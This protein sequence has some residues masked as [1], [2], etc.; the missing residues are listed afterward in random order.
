MQ[1]GCQ[2]SNISYLADNRSC[3]GTIEF[4]RPLVRHS[5][6]VSST[7]RMRYVRIRTLGHTA[8]QPRRQERAEESGRASVVSDD[9]AA[10][11][12]LGFDGGVGRWLA[13]MG[14]MLKSRTEIDEL[15]ATATV[16]L[17]RRRVSQ[18]RRPRL[19][20]SLAQSEP[21]NGD[22]SATS[23]AMAGCVRQSRRW[24]LETSYRFDLHVSGPQ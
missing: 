20:K 7:E 15:P 4:C 9:F 17:T 2:I 13:L 10:A 6:P 19:P 14:A 5:K 22:A 23:D 8:A 3:R 16:V 24:S 12:L 11:A 21:S 1:S 18:P